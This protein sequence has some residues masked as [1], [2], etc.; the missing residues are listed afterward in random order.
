MKCIAKQGIGIAFGTW[1]EFESE[2]QSGIDSKTESG[3]QYEIEGLPRYKSSDCSWQITV[4]VCR[5]QFTVYSFQIAV[6][7]LFVAARNVNFIS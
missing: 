2:T 1:Y 3:T 5:L 6:C 7:S 4:A